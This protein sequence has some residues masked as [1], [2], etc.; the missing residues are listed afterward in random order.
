MLTRHSGKWATG[1]E[2]L[3]W[4]RWKDVAMALQQDR[5]L[6]RIHKESEQ[7]SQSCVEIQLLLFY[8]FFFYWNESWILSG[9]CEHF[10][11]PCAPVLFP[12]PDHPRS[13]NLAVSHCFPLPILPFQVSSLTATQLLC[14]SIIGTLYSFTTSVKRLVKYA[15]TLLYSFSCS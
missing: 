12:F 4:E 15:V 5:C 11:S 14:P 3:E 7:N 10:L 1:K 13:S 9:Q 6:T 8:Y 2:G